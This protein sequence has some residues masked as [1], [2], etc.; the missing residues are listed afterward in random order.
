VTP[1]VASAET[2]KSPPSAP[3]GEPLTLPD[4]EQLLI[5]PLRPGDRQ[6][7]ADAVAGMS[8]RSRYLRF[9]AAKPRF[10][11]RELDFLTHP[12]GDRHVA[13][14]VLEPQTRRGVAVGRY[15]RSDERTADIAV[16]VTDAW[17]RRGIGNLLLA[18][19]IDQARANALSALTATALAENVGSKHMLHTGG[20]VLASRDGVTNDYRL[21]LSA[22]SAPTAAT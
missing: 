9:A 19:L 3:D 11:N 17:Q 12:D 16:G 20:F 6:T 2:H 4:G 1:A 22:A 15:V 5:R 21:E 13:F 7:Y 18:R 14:V 8:V 10:S